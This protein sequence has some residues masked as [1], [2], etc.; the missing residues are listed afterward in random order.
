MPA[1]SALW[2]ATELSASV[3]FVS[4]TAPFCEKIPPPS[5]AA[6]ELEFREIVLL[7]TATAPE[8]V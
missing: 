8:A 6:D 1:P 3:L 4:V 2:P 7:R 5:R